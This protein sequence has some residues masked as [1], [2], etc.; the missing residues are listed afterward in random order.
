MFL[1]QKNHVKQIMLGTKT[2]TRR[3]HKRW[4]ANV[5]AIHQVR[6][7]LFGKPHCHIRILSRWEERLGDISHASARAEGG[8]T[9]AGYISGLIRMHKGA[10]DIN[11]VL[12][13]YEFEL[14]AKSPTPNPNVT[15]HHYFNPGDEP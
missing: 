4:R 6:T 8:Y 3:N 7:E 9:P 10:L 14:V 15:H 2:Q 5:G 1:F 12:K 13:V 11:S